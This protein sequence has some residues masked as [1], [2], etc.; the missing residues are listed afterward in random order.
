MVL[1]WLMF[2][3]F[4]VLVVQALGLL[5]VSELITL[6][7]VFLLSWLLGYLSFVA[8]SGLGVREAFLVA[9]LGPF[10]GAPQ[11][12]AVAAVSRVLMIA[13]EVLMLGLA[14]V[15]AARS[16]RNVERLDGRLT[17]RKI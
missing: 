16:G 10:M 7:G 2:A 6:A 1:S 14:Q 13:V 8:P 11:A 17:V 3:A 4:Q 12:V 5:L 15:T 9:L